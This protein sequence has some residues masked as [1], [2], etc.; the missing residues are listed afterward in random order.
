M[1]KYRPSNPILMKITISGNAGSGKSTIAKLLAEKLHFTHESTGDFFRQLAQERNLTLMQLTKESE[2]SPDIDK[3]VDAMS[4]EFGKTH[5]D[6]VMDSRLAFHFIPDSIKIFLDVHP[7]TAA[8]RIFK[9]PQQSRAVEKNTTLEQVQEDIQKRKESEI[10]RYK[11]LYN[12]DHTDPEHFD[13]LI[14]TTEET[15]EK[16]LDIII[17]FLKVNNKL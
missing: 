16:I 5:D 10:K 9:D 1:F 11:E 8:E 6:F 2:K 17:N 4:A 3:A 12:L 13:L 15:P 14:D 7:S